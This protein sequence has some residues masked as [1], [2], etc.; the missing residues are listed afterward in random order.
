MTSPTI[1]EDP[2]SLERMYI[3]MT[4][5]VGGGTKKEEIEREVL[6]LQY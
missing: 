2:L 6:L 4:S 5:G 1:I 3:H